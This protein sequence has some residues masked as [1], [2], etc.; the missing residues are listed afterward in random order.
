[1]DTVRREDT[2]RG[3]FHPDALRWAVFDPV[4]F[5]RACANST[6]GLYAAAYD[7][8]AEKLN[9]ARNQ[10]FEG[11]YSRLKTALEEMHDEAKQRKG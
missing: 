7:Q 9:D 11:A 3:E 2:V 8:A 4:R 5:L 1:M 10:A 6:G